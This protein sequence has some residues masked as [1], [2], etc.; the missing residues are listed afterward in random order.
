[1]KKIMLALFTVAMVFVITACGDNNG[2]DVADAPT[3]TAPAGG[4][5]S[6]DVEALIAQWRL[7]EPRFTPD[8]NT[9]G[10]RTDTGM[11]EITW[12]VNF[13]WFTPRELGMH[14]VSQ[15]IREDLGIVINFISGDSANLT[16][17]M[18]AG[19]LPDII[20]M[21]AE[22][23]LTFQ[24]HEWAIPLDVL[25]AVYDPYFMANIVPPLVASWHTLPDGH[26]YGMP[27]D[28]WYREAIEAGVAWPNNGFMV[29]EDIFLAIGEPDMSTPDGFLNALRD[30]RDFMPY[31]DH[32]VALVPFAGHA[33][34]I[35]G[36]GTGAFGPS[37]QDFLAIPFVD[38]SGNW[39]DRDA[40]PEYLEWL[41]VFRQALEEGLMNND[42]FSDDN[43][44]IQERL[45]LGTYFAYITPN[46]F[47]VST[48]LTNNNNR[49]P[50]QRY[51]PISGPRNR[52][53]DD[54]THPAGGLNGWVQTFVTQSATDP[55]TAMQVV[56][57]FASD[58]A[59]LLLAFGVEDEHFD[60]VD[61]LAVTRQEA[62]DNNEIHGIGDYWMLRNLAFTNRVG[63]LPFPSI[64]DHVAFSQQFNQA[65]LQMQGIDPN[66][67]G[68]LQRNLGYMNSARTQAIVAVI[69]ASSDA[70]GT[71]I[72]EEFLQNR[73][74]F[75]FNELIEFRNQ[76]ISENNER[77]D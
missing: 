29:R 6:A 45:S 31:A 24:A 68:T 3:T 15:V 16:A 36:G 21:H 25:S 40:N 74:N 46:T 20:T 10:W 56:T 1:M 39:Y 47:D 73:E 50:E 8:V 64:R 61:G 65:R 2:N 70:E 59:N 35:V 26:F 17:M 76:R 58:H 57:Y 66:D 67:G 11:V 4:E 44:F 75:M 5:L 54:H 48:V 38:G 49:A 43:S 27:N 19:D 28:A 41:L 13:G 62:L 23:D 37:L 77:L 30:A 51:I 12:Y 52:A 53:G 34:D 60:W 71:Q 7:P 18:A 72:W 9:P 22:D 33:L 14:T 55:Q 69:Q 42:Q 32:G 63:N